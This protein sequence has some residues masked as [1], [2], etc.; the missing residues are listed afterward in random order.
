MS[1]T[2]TPKVEPRGDGGDDEESGGECHSICYVLG[3]GLSHVNSLDSKNNSM[4]S[5]ILLSP[6]YR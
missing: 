3:T 6:F 1:E 5:V 2:E 4:R